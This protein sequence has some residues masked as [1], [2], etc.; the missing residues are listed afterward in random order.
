MKGG[1]LEE[2]W[3]KYFDVID[4]KDLARIMTKKKDNKRKQFY[5]G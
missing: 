2:G 1:L 4:A 5:K 3:V